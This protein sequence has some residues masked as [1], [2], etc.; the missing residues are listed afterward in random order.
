LP[1]PP[2]RTEQTQVELRCAPTLLDVYPAAASGQAE[3]TAGA[4]ERPT[5]MAGYECSLTNGTAYQLSRL[6][7]IPFSKTAPI[8]RFVSAIW[9]GEESLLRRR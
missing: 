8:S 7:E 5:R 1:L 2:P 6:G 3:H 4:T 9:H